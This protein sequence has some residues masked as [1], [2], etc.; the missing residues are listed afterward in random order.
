MR[1]G[2]EVGRADVRIVPGR[3]IQSAGLRLQGSWPGPKA[4]ICRDP[5]ALGSTRNGE[6][7]GLSPGSGSPDLRLPYALGNRSVASPLQ[8]EEGW[9]HA[10]DTVRH[11]VHRSEL[12]HGNVGA[13]AVR[14]LAL[15]PFSR[16]AERIALDNG[17]S[18][19]FRLQEAFFIEDLVVAQMTKSIL[20]PVEHGEPLDR[21]ALD[22]IAMVLGAHTLQ[23]HCG[24]P[25]FAVAPRRGLEAWQKLRTE[26]MLR[27]HL[28]GNIT[29]KELAGAC[30]LSESHFAR[31]FRTSFGTSVH[32]RLI[33]LRVE[34]AKDLLAQT[35]KS[36]VEVALLSGFCDQAAFTRSFSRME[37]IT[38]SYWRRANASE[39]PLR[40][41]HAK[42]SRGVAAGCSQYVG[43][44]RLTLIR[45][46]SRLTWLKRPKVTAVVD[47]EIRLSARWRALPPRHCSAPRY[48][49]RRRD[50]DPDSCRLSRLVCWQGPS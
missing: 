30:S 40:K 24:A 17:V 27:A 4:R 45:R 9:G 8:R 39:Q 31:C 47:V 50:A 18:T 48:A 46:S 23:A 2:C 49:E 14:L 42:L 28:A 19:S 10:S 15:L 1:F 22:Q 33:Q 35:S 37:H 26:E 43:M 11:D 25:K 41:N 5:A 21:L 36:L 20:I 34:H 7:A 29:V 44:L 3:C 16:T 38:P 13:R 6:G 12:P 32:Q